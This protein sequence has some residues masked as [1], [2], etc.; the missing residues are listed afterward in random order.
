M[1][2]A[3]KPQ[4]QYLYSIR[5][6]CKDRKVMPLDCKTLESTTHI[7]QTFVPLLKHAAGSVN[8]SIHDHPNKATRVQGKLWEFDSVLFFFLM[9]FFFFQFEDN[10]IDPETKVFGLYTSSTA[11]VAQ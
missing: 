3:G 1:L 10:F 6:I 7:L 5:N 2:A 11:Q 4:R 8:V 9:T